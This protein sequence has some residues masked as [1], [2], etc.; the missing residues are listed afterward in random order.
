MEYSGRM[1]TFSPEARRMDDFILA[2]AELYSLGGF[3][4][5]VLTNDDSTVKGEIWDVPRK[6][7]PKLDRYESEGYLYLREVVA[8]I[9]TNTPVFAYIYNHDVNSCTKI[10]DGDWLQYIN[11]ARGVRA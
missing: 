7:V 9:A 1:N 6:D 2:G 4:G 5:L 8:A 10:P 3:P 11:K